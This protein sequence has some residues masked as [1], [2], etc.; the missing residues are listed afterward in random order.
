MNKLKKQISN[1]SQSSGK[2][3]DI[4]A[5]CDDTNKSSYEDGEY[6]NF[7]LME[8]RYEINEAYLNT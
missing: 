6:V 4:I 7:F 8:P 3:R 5:T 1:K 2:K